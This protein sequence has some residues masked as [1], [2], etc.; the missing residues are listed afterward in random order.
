MRGEESWTGAPCP[1]VRS[2]E[3]AA[4]L[5]RLFREF[6]LEDIRT[7]DWSEEVAPFWGAVIGTALT[8]EGISG[9]LKAG[10]TTIKGSLVMPLMAEG[11][12]TGTIKFNII[13]ATKP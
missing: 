13:T 7:G 8:P 10:W 2:V 12:Q 5:C 1:W 11:F 6:G 4:R 3:S 9:L